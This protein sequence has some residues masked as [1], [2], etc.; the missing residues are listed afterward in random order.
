MRQAVHLSTSRW[1]VSLLALSLLFVA[2]HAS[3]SQGQTHRSSANREPI[4]VGMVALLAAPQSYEGKFIR[5]HGFLCIEFEDDALN[6]HE[7]DYRYALSKNSFAL[8][9][10]ESQRKQFKSMSLK[11]VLIEGRVYANG[12]ERDDWAGAIGNI[13]RL[14]VWPFDKSPAQHP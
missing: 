5:T 14:E 7:E 4:D 6:L 9:L 11:Y 3:P 8:R 13:T 2:D 10:S 1:I 12:P